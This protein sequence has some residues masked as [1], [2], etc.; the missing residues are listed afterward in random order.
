MKQ[1]GCLKRTKRA[2]LPTRFPPIKRREF[3]S[4]LG[5]AAA[6]SAKDALARTVL[7][8]ASTEGPQAE[9]SF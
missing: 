7:L 4:L 3:I 6:R 8:A 5:G 1:N 2:D 9:L